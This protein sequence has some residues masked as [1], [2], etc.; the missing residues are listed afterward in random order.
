MNVYIVFVL[1]VLLIWIL[2]SGEN[3]KFIEQHTKEMIKDK[4][5][6]DKDRI[7]VTY[8]GNKYDLTDFVAKH[9]GGS[10]ILINAKDSDIEEAMIENNHSNNA[11]RMLERYRINDVSNCS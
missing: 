11:F 4:K 8:Q 1:C 3:K 7:I 6:T 5:K 2:F 9:P 10:Q